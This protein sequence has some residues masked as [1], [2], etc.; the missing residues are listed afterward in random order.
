MTKPDFN[1]DA[2]LFGRGNKLRV[3]RNSSK[4][5]DLVREFK[6]KRPAD[7][8]FYSIMQDGKVYTAMEIEHDLYAHP[9]FPK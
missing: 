6:D 9:D 3:P 2:E 8:R 5:P 7:R 1:A 4:L